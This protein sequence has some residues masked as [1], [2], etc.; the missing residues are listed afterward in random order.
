MIASFTV[1]MEKT[2]DAS[3]FA[4]RGL[5]TWWNYAKQFKDRFGLKTVTLRY[6]NVI[7]PP[8]DPLEPTQP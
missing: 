1:A 7:G 5:F 6:F 8:Q 4:R 2:T 3:A